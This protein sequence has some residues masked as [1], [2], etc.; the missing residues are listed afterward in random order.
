MNKNIVYLNTFS[1]VCINYKVILC[2]LT[3]ITKN[4][5]VYKYKIILCNMKK[6]I[7]KTG[8]SLCII[9]DREDC[10][11]LELKE[12]DIV[13]ISDIVKINKKGGKN[14]SKN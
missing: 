7:K 14:G 6:I 2:N 11:I 13:D 10:K 9:F 3:V 4:S 1:F 5:K 12:G 8:N